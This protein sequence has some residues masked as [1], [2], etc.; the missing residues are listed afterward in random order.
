MSANESKAEYIARRKEKELLK[1]LPIVNTCEVIHRVNSYTTVFINNIRLLVI[2]T[3]QG[4]IIY[5]LAT[6]EL[7]FDW[8]FDLN[9]SLMFVSSACKRV[10][11]TVNPFNL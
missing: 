2:Q 9:N 7:A 3:E 6:D 10:T 5:E 11:I 4:E 1:K 8:V